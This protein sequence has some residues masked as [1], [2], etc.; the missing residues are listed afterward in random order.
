MDFSQMYDIALASGYCCTCIRKEK[1][2]TAVL[3]MNY[4]IMFFSIMKTVGMP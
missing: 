1:E 2:K 3:K 4:K